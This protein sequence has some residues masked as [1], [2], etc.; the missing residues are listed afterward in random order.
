MHI[1]RP[2]G[3][4]DSDN[5]CPVLY[6]IHGGGDD[7]AAWSTIGR[8]GFILDNLLAAGKVAPSHLDTFAYIGVLSMGLQVGKHAGV[9]TDF[10]AR[11][12]D[13]FGDPDRTSALLKMLWIAAG[14][15]DRTITDGARRLSAT[16]TRR[17]IR[18]GFHET[19][20]GHTW[21]NWRHYL[22]DFSQL[23]FRE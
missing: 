18:H 12:A 2:P 20:G 14:E 5:S 19:A 23:L 6:L 13:F 9:N 3:Y 21:I 10:E 15:D 22:H 7:D 16:L 11:N 8:A 17:G 1:Y 4:G